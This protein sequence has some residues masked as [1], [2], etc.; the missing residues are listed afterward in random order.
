MVPVIAAAL[1][2]LAQGLG[3]STR[4]E[5]VPLIGNEGPDLDACIGIG[6]IATLEPSLPVREQPDDYA[7]EKD[8][9]APSTLVWL[10][11]KG[12]GETGE[13]WQGIVYPSGEHQELGDCRVSSPVSEPRPYAGP[14]RSGWVIAR[15]IRLVAG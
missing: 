7:R 8:R 5:Q 2:I 9:L 1:L 14:C 10:C 15:D 12:G 6:R 4:V 11:E 3:P 13:D